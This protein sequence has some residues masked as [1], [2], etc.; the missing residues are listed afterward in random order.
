M[1]W[2]YNKI[3]END[4]AVN[5]AYGWNTKETTGQIEYNKNTHKLTVVKVAD[6]DNKTGADW[7]ASHLPS[8]FKNGYPEKDI[9]IIG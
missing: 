2:H 8:I 9:V 6:N 7:A 4:N 5:Y 3:C 1:L